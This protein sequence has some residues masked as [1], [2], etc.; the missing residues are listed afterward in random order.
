M[1]TASDNQKIINPLIIVMVDW[2]LI[3]AAQSALHWNLCSSVKNGNCWLLCQLT[4]LQTE[5]TWSD[6][7][8]QSSCV[9]NCYLTRITLSEYIIS[10]VWLRWMSRELFLTAS[11]P[12]VPNPSHSTCDGYTQHLWHWLKY[13]LCLSNKKIWLI[14]NSL[15]KSFRKVWS[16]VIE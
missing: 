3:P 1:E 10:N 13:I 14:V 6:R 8:Q 16:Q 12:H 2:T 9:T 7:S 11:P 15:S 5:K 4:P